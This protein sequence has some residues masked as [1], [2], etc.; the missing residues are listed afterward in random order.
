[1]MLAA[2]F[3]LAGCETTGLASK[4]GLMSISPGMTRDQVVGLVGPPG[5]RTFRDRNEA[6]Q[7]CRTG[8]NSDE[9]TTVWLTDGKVTGLTTGNHALIPMG[10]CAGRFP[11]VDWGQIPADVRVSIER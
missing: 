10:S 1:M 8:M 4:A 6:L 7:Y 9:Y 3:A 5:N 11:P 2:V